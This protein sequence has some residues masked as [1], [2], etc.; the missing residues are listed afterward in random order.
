MWSFK[1][2]PEKI[3]WAG[4]NIP[5]HPSMDKN[6]AT[7]IGVILLRTENIMAAID[8]A[9]T[10]LETLKADLATLLAKPAGVPE[11]SVQAIAD[12]IAALDVTVKAAL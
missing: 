9:N 4:T 5:I 2:K 6:T 7:I 8:T 11:A 3:Y 10:N 12:G 1:T